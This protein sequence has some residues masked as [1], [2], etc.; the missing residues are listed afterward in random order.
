M[1]ATASENVATLQRLGQ[2]EGLCQFGSLSWEWIWK[3]MVV[4][5][6]QELNRP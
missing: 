5:E 3:V 4:R 1:V 6:E 2:D